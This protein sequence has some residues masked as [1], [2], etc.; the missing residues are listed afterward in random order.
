MAAYVRVTMNVRDSISGQF[1]DGVNRH[2]FDCMNESCFVEGGSLTAHCYIEEILGQHVLAFA[3]FIGDNYVLMQDNTR[4]CV[5]RYVLQYLNE[6]GIQLMQWP[7]RSPDLNP[8]DHLWDILGRNVRQHAPDI[9]Q[10]L[11]SHNFVIP[12]LRNHDME[13]IIFVQDGAPPYIFIHAKQLIT[14]MFGNHVIN[15]HFPRMWPPRSPDFN[16]ADFWLWSYLKEQVFLTHP[17]LLQLKDAISHEIA[18]IPRHYLQNAVHGVADRMLSE[19]ITKIFLQL[20]KEIISIFRSQLGLLIDKQTHGGPGTSNDYNTAHR[21]FENPQITAN[22]TGIKDGE[23][24]KKEEWETEKEGEEK[25]QE[26]ELDKDEEEEEEMNCSDFAEHGSK[27]EINKNK[28][29]VGQTYVGFQKVGN[30]MLQDC[31]RETRK[32]L[33]QRCKYTKATKIT[34]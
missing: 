12:R 5:A 2:Q 23:E 26:E 30:E 8:I 15:R 28:R 16:P 29:L 18:N 7:S 20:E 25:G 10:E 6:V 31:A 14:Q 3:S 17:T 21:F 1:S 22:I 34:Q 11:R 24:E 27:M 13:N 19:T 4:P 33:Y 9:L 32:L